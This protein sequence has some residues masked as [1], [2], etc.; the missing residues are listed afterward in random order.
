[1][2]LLIIIPA[3]NEEENIERVVNNLQK[4]YS[5]YDYVV[6]NDGSKDNTE[7]ICL[8]HGFNL[9]SLPVN[10]GLAG[11]F[12][13][14]MVYAKKHDYDYAIQFDGDGQHNPEYIE[15][16]L[17]KFEEDYDIVIGSRFATE[18]KPGGMR[19]AGSNIIQ[20]AI[21]LT[22]GKLIKDPTSGM[23]IFNKKMIKRFASYNNYGP[24]PDTV[25]YLM[26]TGAKVAE[27]QVTMSERTA[28]ESYLK[29]AKAIWYMFRICFSI[30]FIQWF[31]KE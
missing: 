24:E 19:M 30:I 3:Y 4:N 26:R 29:P 17:K 8:Q 2:S 6:V 21:R 15:E 31:R 13:A 25:A 16:M 27:V 1:M 14:G 9:V 5:Q 18:K 10:L 12:K 28:G 23:R 7:K 22:T 11:A 20:S